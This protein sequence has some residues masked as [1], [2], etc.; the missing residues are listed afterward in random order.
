M[1]YYA[2]TYMRL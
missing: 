2:R 1:R